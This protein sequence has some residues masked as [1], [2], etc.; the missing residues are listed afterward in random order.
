MKRATNTTENTNSIKQKTNTILEGIVIAVTSISDNQ[1][2]K[3][4][5]YWTALICDVN[6][7][8]N[9]ITK[10]VSLKSN[11]FIHTKMLDHLN[12]QRGIKLNKLKFNDDNT[13]V[14]TSETVAVEKILALTPLCTQIT[15]IKNIECMSDGEYVSFI[16]KVVEIGSDES[17]LLNNGSKR[18]QKL[19]RT[20]V[21][22]DN[23]NSIIMNIWENHFD[24]IKKDVCY[25]IKLAKAKMFNNEITLTTTVHTT[26]ETIE[27]IHIINISTTP[28]ISTESAV[29]GTITSIGRVQETCKCPKCYSTDVECNGKTIKCT[30]CNSRSVYLTKS[31]T[32][33][34]LTLSILD[35][36]QI[37]LEFTVDIS[38]LCELL[39]RC[40]RQ[41]LC[42]NDLVDHED[43]LLTLSSI[44]VF[45]HYNTRNM[46][47]NNIVLNN[48]DNK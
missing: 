37:T 24:V 17:V 14:A 19:K 38:K 34:K 12:N 30:T 21:I 25:R 31:T 16:C 36:N 26:F 47:I 43:V 48:I 5:K 41:D 8:V 20:T 13:Y 1:N 18:I 29:I 11:C 45:V 6:Q 7:N 32:S 3:K 33:E 28:Q 27:D 40:G 39:E 2:D 42:N 9:R 4:G 44:T 10:Y 35:T 15:T 23:T 22:A 46:Q